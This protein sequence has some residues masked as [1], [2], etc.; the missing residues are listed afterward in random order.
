[1]SIYN[2]SSYNEDDSKNK[3][4][5]KLFGSFIII[6][7]FLSYF[8]L[9]TFPYTFN[10]L[11]NAWYKYFKSW[12]ITTDEAVFWY[13][14]DYKNILSTLNLDLNKE[15]EIIKSVFNLNNENEKFIYD[16]IISNNLD[17]IGSIDFIDRLYS[18]VL[19][20]QFL[21][22]FKWDKVK[23]NS[24]K[25]SSKI[26]KAKLLKIILNPSQDFRNNNWIY[27][28]WT[29]LK[30]YISE[31]NRRLLNDNLITFFTKYLYKEN[32]TSETVE[33]LKKLW[34]K[35]LIVDLNAAT[36]DNDPR[37][38]LTSRFEWLLKTF[39]DENLEL[40]DTDSLCLNLSLERYS[41]SEKTPNDLQ[42]Y[43][44]LWW[45]NHESY[46][47]NNTKVVLRRSKMKT[48]HWEISKLFLK[49]SINNDNYSFLLPVY[50][51]YK[52]LAKNE[53]LKSEEDI[54][55]FLSIKVKSWS[56]ALFE[57]K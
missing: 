56:K 25:V 34:F 30:Y 11:K 4:T 45:V 42:V 40:I 8:F 39:T 55:K 41:K 38:D 47:E 16:L 50:N 10:N 46:I 26:I 17:I 36:I 52:S 9:S 31:N 24:I 5:I 12:E 18:W 15:N 53:Q 37:R 48:C 7:I 21:P 23:L 28:I 44:Y 35:Y 2:L 43:L 13:H 32:S 6:F 1:M 3:K 27:R 20:K 49:N 54:L 14:T 22:L 57:I 19:D 51:E 29:F 33:N